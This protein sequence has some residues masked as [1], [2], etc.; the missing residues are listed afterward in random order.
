M[1]SQ[2]LV[3]GSRADLQVDDLGGGSWGAPGAVS[4]SPCKARRSQQL[5]SGGERAGRS[6]LSGPPAGDQGSRVV[7][8]YPMA[9]LWTEN[10]GLSIRLA[11]RTTSAHPLYF[12]FLS[13]PR[14][15][16]G[17]LLAGGG[18]GRA[19]TFWVLIKSPCSLDP[20]WCHFGSEGHGCFSPRL[21]EANG[22]ACRERG[23]FSQ[24]C[25]AFRMG[26]PGRSARKESAHNAGDLSSIPGLGS[27]PGEGNGYLLQYSGLENPI[28]LLGLFHP[29]S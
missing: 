25:A 24:L 3:V 26:F 10:G 21:G 5:W 28:L 15:S 23:G 7:A 13:F 6:S 14:W 11:W 12:L 17:V 1:C 9:R 16:G 22:W 20:Y 4:W 29:Y 19:F 2:P 18:K 8:S 27:S